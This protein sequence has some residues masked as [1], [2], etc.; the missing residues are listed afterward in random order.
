MAKRRNVAR[1]N[2]AYI[3][4]HDAQVK[5]QK[6]RRKKLYRRLTLFGIIA[7]TALFLLVAFHVDQ[8]TR[9][10]DMQ[11]EYEQKTTELAKLE[12]EEKLLE[13]EIELLQD[14]EYLLQIAKTDYFFTEEGE[15]VF[16]T[17][18]EEASY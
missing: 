18:E 2:E 14:E 16:K 5:R 3:E 12:K 4:Q 7:F 1:I 15:I 10:T 6:R 17:A 13:N 9:L 11:Q 8:R